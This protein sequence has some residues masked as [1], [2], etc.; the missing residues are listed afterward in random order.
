[1]RSNPTTTQSATASRTTLPTARHIGNGAVPL[2]PREALRHEVSYASEGSTSVRQ[3]LVVG[4]SWQMTR[5]VVR[6]VWTHC[7]ILSNSNKKR[8]ERHKVS[9]K[10][11]IHPSLRTPN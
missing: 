9:T 7:Q 8:G 1:M 10:G 5:T 6:R 11:S 4:T 2:I 3:L